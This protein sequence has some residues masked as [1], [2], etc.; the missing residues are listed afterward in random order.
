MRNLHALSAA[1]AVGFVLCLAGFSFVMFSILASGAYA[2]ETL[3]IT[4]V[5]GVLGR[6]GTRAGWPILFGYAAG[7]AGW[8]ATFALRRDGKHRMEAFASYS[9][10]A[11]ASRLGK[12][13]IAFS[14]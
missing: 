1:A 14:A 3:S 13:P 2:N 9:A 4:G 8:L 10:V 11:A 6:V 7:M 12:K 5:G